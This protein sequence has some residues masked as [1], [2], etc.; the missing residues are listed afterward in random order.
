MDN[1]QIPAD[2]IRFIESPQTSAFMIRQ[3]YADD[4]RFRIQ[5]DSYSEQKLKQKIAADAARKCMYKREEY[6]NIMLSS[7]SSDWAKYQSSK[8]LE[9][10]IAHQMKGNFIPSRVSLLRAVRE[11]GLKRTDGGSE[12]GDR[13]QAQINAQKNFDALVAE[14]QRI[15]LSPEELLEFGS[16]SARDLS[17]RFFDENND[18]FRI[19]YTM[20]CQQFGYRQPLQFADEAQR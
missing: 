7:A 14:A 2:V 9:L 8:H 4:P 20:A 11:L 13:R 15:P 17:R 10:V 6:T 5:F 12:A 3:R 18:Y 1:Q 16:L 19:R